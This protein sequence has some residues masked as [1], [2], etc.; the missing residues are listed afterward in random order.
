MLW[1]RL[2]DTGPNPEVAEFFGFVFLKSAF[3]SDDLQIQL[4]IFLD[5]TYRNIIGRHINSN[6]WWQGG[7]SRHTAAL[8]YNIIQ[9]IRTV[10][11]Y[12]VIFFT[13]FPA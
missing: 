13:Y 11:V 12:H 8:A 9:H 1:F 5:E 6:S 2:G 3:D 10:G 7:S 4:L